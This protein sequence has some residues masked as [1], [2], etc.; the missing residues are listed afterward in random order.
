MD[1]K[2]LF[3]ALIGLIIFEDL[4]IQV[5]GTSPEINQLLNLPQDFYIKDFFQTNNTGISQFLRFK[6]AIG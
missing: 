3:W 5:T 6:L 4:K 1:T 2:F